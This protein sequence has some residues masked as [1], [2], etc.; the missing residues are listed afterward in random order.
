MPLVKIFHANRGYAYRDPEALN[1]ALEAAV[2]VVAQR[3]RQLAVEEALVT[4]LTA[5]KVD[6]DNQVA[7][8]KAR[9][10][11]QRKLKRACA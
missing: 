7:A 10:A 8:D 11:E 4:K 1:S 9:K 2:A 5:A 3:R 6:L